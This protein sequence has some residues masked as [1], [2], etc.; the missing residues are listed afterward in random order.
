LKSS[1]SPLAVQVKENL[2]KSINATTTAQDVSAFFNTAREKYTDIKD[3]A[4]SVFS[5]IY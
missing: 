2:S 1:N 4:V 5:K 3:M